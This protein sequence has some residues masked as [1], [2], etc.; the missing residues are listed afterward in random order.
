MGRPA[1]PLISRFFPHES[2]PYRRLERTV[3]AHC[4]PQTVLLDA[5]CG[6]SA[7][8]LIRLSKH[9]GRSIGVDIVH[10][11][12]EAARNVNIELV[13]A[14]LESL[15]LQDASIDLAYSVSVMEHLREPEAVYREIYRVL[16]PGGRFLFLTPNFWDYASLAAKIIPNRFHPWLVRHT[17]GRP[18]EDTFPTY[19]RSNTHSSIRRLA[20]STGFELEQIEYQ[21]QYPSYFLFSKTL[22]MLGVGYQKI[23]ERTPWLEFLQGWIF[24][25]LRR[26]D[27]HELLASPGK[28]FV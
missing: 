22:F 7:E 11:T 14:G 20:R 28:R 19:F 8:R 9:A 13:Q 12:P 25:H 15:P 23:I 17:E 6:R 5:G 10:F 16:R 4:T 24:A 21:G 3:I 2:H 1:E 27:A 18:E 26:P